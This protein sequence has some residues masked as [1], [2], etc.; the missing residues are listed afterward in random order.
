MASFD[1]EYQTLKKSYGTSSEILKLNYVNSTIVVN[2]MEEKT[3]LMSFDSEYEH[4]F[5][6]WLA[7]I[8]FE[9]FA[10]KECQDVDLGYEGQGR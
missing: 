5:I 7:L 4:P 3:G 6:Y 1:G 10:L 8:V 2:V 9:I